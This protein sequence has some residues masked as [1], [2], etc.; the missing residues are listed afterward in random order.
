MV[1]AM[2]TSIGALHDE[3]IRIVGLPDTE[4]LCNTTNPNPYLLALSGT[5]LVLCVHSGRFDVV[6]G[7]RNYTVA[8][9]KR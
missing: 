2:P 7:V 6:L 5:S 4:R 9:E 8:E 1:Q 3:H